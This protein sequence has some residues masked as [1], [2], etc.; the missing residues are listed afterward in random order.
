LANLHQPVLRSEFLNRYALRLGLE[1]SVLK[2]EV[3]H[4]E[5]G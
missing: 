4:Y 1:H 5:T 2:A 3:E